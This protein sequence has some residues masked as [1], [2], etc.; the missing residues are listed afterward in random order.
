MGKKKK[1]K[2]TRPTKWTECHKVAKKN[3]GAYQRTIDTSK[4]IRSIITTTKAV[5]ED[6]VG[7]ITD[8]PSLP[9]TFLSEQSE[10]RKDKG[11]G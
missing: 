2:S 11:E 5:G 9:L 7:G 8:T 3:R 4:E 6:E 1:R 10:E